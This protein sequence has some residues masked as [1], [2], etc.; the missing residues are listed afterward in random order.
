MKNI[1]I[2]AIIKDNLILK[3]DLYSVKSGNFDD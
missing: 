2:S 3:V 1:K